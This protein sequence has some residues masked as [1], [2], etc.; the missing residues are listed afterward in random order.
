MQLL[1]FFH[2]HVREFLCR[3]VFH[4]LLLPLLQSEGFLLAVQLSLVHL[5]VTIDLLNLALHQLFEILWLS[6]MLP[7][8]LAHDV[9]PFLEVVA[10]SLA[11]LPP[12]HRVQSIPVETVLLLHNLVDGVHVTVAPQGLCVLHE[13]H[14]QS[15]HLDHLG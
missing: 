8:D 1:K 11:A 3:E 9:A 6:Q 13:L 10:E 7:D 12:E 14:Q 2:L 4:A 5:I 15:V